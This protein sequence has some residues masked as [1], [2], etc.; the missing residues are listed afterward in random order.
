MLLKKRLLLIIP[1]V[2]II[3]AAVIVLSSLHKD[4]A[5]VPVMEPSLDVVT[6]TSPTAEADKPLNERLIDNLD[7][8]ADDSAVS[9]AWN[10]SHDNIKVDS[11]YEGNFTDS[12]KNELLVIFKLLQ[13]PHAG[14]L[15]C[16]VAAVFDKETL[17]LLAQKTFPAD[18]CRFEVLKDNKGR[19]YLLFG[20]TTTY[21]GHS[22]HTL[23]LFKPDSDW[24]QLLTQNGDAYADTGNYNFELLPGGMV[25]VSAA[26]YSD[27]GSGGEPEWR[28]GYMLRWDPETATLKDYVPDTYLNAD[29][30]SYFGTAS[31][32]PDGKYAVVPHE[33]GFDGSYYVLLYNIEKNKL[34]G[35]Y[36]LPAMYFGFTWSPDGKKV[37]VSRLARIW[38]DLSVLS[39][40]DG[41]ISKEMGNVPERFKSLGIKLNYELNEN[42]PDPA[43]TLLE[44]SPDS[45]K[46]L[47][48]YQWYDKDIKKQSGTFVYNIADK[49][50]SRVRQNAPA[51]ADNID[52]TK[53]DGFAW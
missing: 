37:C 42:R 32:S 49:S 5:S 46:L 17:Q 44:W 53:P 18:I 21:Q 29:G 12:G 10:L 3:V 23:Q 8:T 6:Q 31:V 47:V 48:F 11:T 27:D 24:K 38:T 51:D 9:Y 33:W 13:M 15:D 30:K 39:V 35:K 14:G 43:Y 34:V 2:C 4:T 26:V 25:N 22:S 1:V 40:E 7:K 28:I 20:G 52:K 19:G 50:I 36:E 16:S 45:E 41:I